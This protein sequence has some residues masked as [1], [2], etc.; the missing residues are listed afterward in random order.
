[1]VPP[2]SLVDALHAIHSTH[3]LR[4]SGYNL[5]VGAEF[6]PTNGLYRCKDGRYIMIEAGPPYPK[7]ERG[8]LDFFDCGNNRPALAR[9]V[10]KYDSEDLQEK[11]SALGLPACVARTRQEWLDHLQGAALAKIPPIEIEKIAEGTPN[12]SPYSRLSADRSS[13]TG[14]DACPG[15]STEHT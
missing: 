4:Q 15:R 9:E 14:H 6:V 12:L 7:L 13:C 8:Y 5:S 2:V 11:L 3:Y 10:A 1:M